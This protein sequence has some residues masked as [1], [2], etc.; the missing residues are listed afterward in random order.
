MLGFE[1]NPCGQPAR[2]VSMLKW[3]ALVGALLTSVTLQAQGDDAYLKALA[4]E[5]E[6]V[7][8]KNTDDADHAAGGASGNAAGNPSTDIASFEQELKDNYQ[9][10]YTFYSRLPPRSQEEIFADYK[11]GAPIA[12]I[13]KKIMNRFMHKQ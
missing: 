2:L 3:S 1:C 4:A 8:V 10:S 5:A 6:K 12:D 11:G 7:G 9:G 13:R